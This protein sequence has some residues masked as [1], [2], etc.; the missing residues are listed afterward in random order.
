MCVWSSTRSQHIVLVCF[1]P[2]TKLV[3][4]SP[5]GMSFLLTA[6]DVLAV[7]LSCSLVPNTNF[8]TPC[9]NQYL[10]QDDTKTILHIELTSMLDS[11]LPSLAQL[12]HP[13]SL[14]SE[15]GRAHV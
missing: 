3:L 10:K 9:G 2:S 8:T 14:V 15:I 12:Y 13:F 6:Y 7:V 5:S 1:S 4:S 11:D